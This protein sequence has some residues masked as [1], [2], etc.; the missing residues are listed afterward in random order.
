MGIATNET[1]W[2][3]S[4]VSKWYSRASE[5]IHVAQT[6]NLGRLLGQSLIVHHVW[7]RQGTLNY[8]SHAAKAA[9]YSKVAFDRCMI[10]KKTLITDA[11]ASHTHDVRA[12][13]DVINLIVETGGRLEIL[14]GSRTNNSGRGSRS[15]RTVDALI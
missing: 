2:D 11:T 10:S 3:V 1:V 12:E 14:W 6:L 15:A 13:H 4:L 9:G 7:T 8:I 5:P